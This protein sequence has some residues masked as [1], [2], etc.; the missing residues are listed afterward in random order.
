MAI[1]QRRSVLAWAPA[2]GVFA[3]AGRAAAQQPVHKLLVG[4]VAPLSASW[5]LLIAKDTGIFAAESLDVAFVYAGGT[6][7]VTQQLIGGSIDIASTS[8][9]SAVL[10]IDKG[11]PI[12]LIGGSIMAYPFTVV[13][14][15]DIHNAKDMRGKRIILPYK[16]NV[17]TVLWNRW[18]QENGVD[19]SEVD[20]VFDGSS[21]NRYRALESGTAQAAGITQPYDVAAMAAG[22][23]MLLDISHFVPHI[24]QQ[25]YAVRK[26]W[27][28]QNADI[29]RAFLRATLKGVHYFYQPENRQSCLDILVR[30]A[31]I[32]PDVAA[33]TYDYYITRLHPFVTNGSIPD[34]AVK[35]LI[36]VMSQIDVLQDKSA[37]TSRFVDLK[38]LP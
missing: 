33:G 9:E 12:V 28:A 6:T 7:Q 26:D 16:A 4:D 2:L 18:L 17:V 31:K 22:Y 13:A 37:S 32:A 15:K 1:L 21:A 30:N 27:L 38:Y 10:A 36:D 19:P 3:L 35:N 34:E 25:G 29:A 8:F 5:P 24:A 23:P 14:A 20:Q 11:A